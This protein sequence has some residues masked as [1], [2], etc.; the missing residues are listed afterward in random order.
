MVLLFGGLL[1]RVTRAQRPPKTKR[2]MGHQ[3]Q[4]QPQ[5]QPPDGEPSQPGTRP[6]P[7]W[8]AQHVPETLEPPGNPY[9]QPGEVGKAGSAWDV[10]MTDCHWTKKFRFITQDPTCTVVL[11]KHNIQ[12]I[13]ELKLTSI[14][15]WYLTK[16]LHNQ[17][18]N[19]CHFI[20][21]LTYFLS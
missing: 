10:K 20:H 3:A 8:G 7:W 14:I 9:I 2:A 1:T 17:E 18:N 12:V 6:G 11:F 15:L 5:Q 21:W 16:L 4:S 13:V 19:C